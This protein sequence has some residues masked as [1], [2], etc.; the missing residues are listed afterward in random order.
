MG[1]LL[2]LL[3]QHLLLLVGQST[4]Q[5]CSYGSML[6]Q[7]IRKPSPAIDQSFYWIAD[8]CYLLC[9]PAAYCCVSGGVITEPVTANSNDYSYVHRD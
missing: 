1:L 8:V 5:L 6:M 2:L 9:L 4:L 7:G 3:R